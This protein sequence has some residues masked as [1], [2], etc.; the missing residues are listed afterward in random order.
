MTGSRLIRFASFA[1]ALALV[2]APLH[3]A[4]AGFFGDPRVVAFTIEAPLQQLFDRGRK[5]ESFSVPARVRVAET[6]R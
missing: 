5:D 2:I 4:A 6:A 3:G 1:G